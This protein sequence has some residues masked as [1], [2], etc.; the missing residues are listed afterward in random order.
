MNELSPLSQTQNRRLLL[1]RDLP[2]EPTC[3]FLAGY[4]L[5]HKVALKLHC[6]IVGIPIPPTPDDG[7]LYPLLHIIHTN[8]T[9]DLKSKGL[10]FR[11]DVRFTGTGNPLSTILA[12]QGGY[13]FRGP[14]PKL[15][16]GDEEDAIREWLKTKVTRQRPFMLLSYL[17]YRHS[18]GGLP[19]EGHL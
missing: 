1:P 2:C 9:E 4:V 14:L 16:E 6:T 17:V 15:T 8:I 5:D 19:M 10:N 3:S 13:A 11:V 18:L 12:A 7:Y